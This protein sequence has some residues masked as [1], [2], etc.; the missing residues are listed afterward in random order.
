[1]TWSEIGPILLTILTG[2]AAIAGLVCV[3][4]L[5]RGASLSERKLAEEMA[6]TDGLRPEYVVSWS[7]YDG[8]YLAWTD[9]Y[10]SL[11]WL[12]KDPVSAIR[13]L[14][15]MIGDIEKETPNVENFSTDVEN[16]STGVENFSTK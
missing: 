6:R 7:E 16:L 13:G 10:P 12:D 8:E 3:W 11:S 2:I 14:Y 15:A 4:C 5:L 1:M 9:S